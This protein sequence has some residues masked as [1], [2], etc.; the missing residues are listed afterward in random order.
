[1]NQKIGL[2]INDIILIHIRCHRIKETNILSSLLPWI[3]PYN[4]VHQI[5]KSCFY[6]KL[7]LWLAFLLCLYALSVLWEIK[8]PLSA[9][10]DS[11][12]VLTSSKS[13]F[14]PLRLSSLVAVKKIS[15]RHMGRYFGAFSSTCAEITTAHMLTNISTKYVQI[16]CISKVK[17]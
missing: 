10:K 2:F 16:I 9:Y 14:S 4:N 7:I 8:S 6:I 15:C 1:M 17:Q 12:L 5:L 13:A 11:H 3:R